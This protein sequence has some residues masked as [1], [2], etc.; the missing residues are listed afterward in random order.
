[1]NLKYFLRKNILEAITIQ[2]CG[3]NATSSMRFK[4]IFYYFIG[5][6]TKPQKA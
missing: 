1:M 4:A 3:G 5:E 2:D 6:E